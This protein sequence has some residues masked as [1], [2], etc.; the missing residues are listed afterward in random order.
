MALTINLMPGAAHIV[1]KPR[2]YLRNRPN[3]DGPGDEDNEEG[4]AE[5][6]RGRG[7]EK[8]GGKKKERKTYNN[9]P[10][11]CRRRSQNREGQQASAVGAEVP[12]EQEPEGEEEGEEE[13]GETPKGPPVEVPCVGGVPPPWRKMQTSWDSP[14]NVR[15][16]CCR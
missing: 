6:G 12:E 13:D 2:L 14:Q 3:P 16:C 7:G 4:G 1:A 8:G 10:L 9:P 11:T 5:T 15:T